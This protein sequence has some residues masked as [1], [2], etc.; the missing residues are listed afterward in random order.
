MGLA[1]FFAAL[2]AP[3]AKRVLSALGF[4]FVSY[5]GLSI[6]LNSAID[7]VRSAYGGISGDTLAL[8]QLSGMGTAISIICGALVGR[9]SV[10]A[11]RK[12][13]LLA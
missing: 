4:G 1:S 11:L 6:A 12:L 13:Q 8:I 3:L 9:L 7:Q 5:T 10:V 2:A